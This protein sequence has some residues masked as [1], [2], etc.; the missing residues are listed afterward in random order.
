[1]ISTYYYFG[2]FREKKS[3]AV[4][5]EFHPAKDATPKETKHT[6]WKKV[7]SG[8]TSVFLSGIC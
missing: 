6:L 5:I 7:T 3:N 8:L 1:M 2:Y 4:T